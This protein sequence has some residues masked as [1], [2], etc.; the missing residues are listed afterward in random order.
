MALVQYI[1]TSVL[2]TQ[3][4]PQHAYNACLLSADLCRKFGISG[5]VFAN[6]QQALAITEG[7]DAVATRY[8]KAVSEDPMA[9]TVLLH[10]K[11]EI[12]VREFPDFSILLNVD[13]PFAPDRYVKPLTAETMQDV[14]P[15]NLS[16]KVRILAEAYLDPEMLAC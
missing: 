12:A 2:A 10:V 7:P 11:R 3:M 9:A 6:C 13:Y 8:F 14:W 15:K 5:R 16:A 4:T 1:Y